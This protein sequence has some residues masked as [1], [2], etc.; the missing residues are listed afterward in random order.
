QPRRNVQSMDQRRPIRDP[1]RPPPPAT[2]HERDTRHSD[3]G[4]PRTRRNA[5]SSQ[6]RLLVATD[7]Q[8]DRGLRGRMR[9]M[10]TNQNTHASTTRP[11][12][13]NT[14]P[15]ERQPIPSRG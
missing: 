13:Q 2:P 11:P 14:S 10:P 15:N 7:G 5:P 9:G 12:V 4:T 3:G 1:T 8:M 6:D